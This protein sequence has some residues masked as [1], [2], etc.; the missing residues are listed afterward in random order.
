MSYAC[1]EGTM[2]LEVVRSLLKAKAK[3]NTAAV[4]AN[5]CTPLHYAASADGAHDI[6]EVMLN[7]GANTLSVDDEGCVDL[8]ECVKILTRQC[9]CVR[10]CSLRRR[11]LQRMSILTRDRQIHSIRLR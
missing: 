3:P 11:Q 5:S 9:T 7:A 2:S 6:I 4:G 8:S 1:S 10:A